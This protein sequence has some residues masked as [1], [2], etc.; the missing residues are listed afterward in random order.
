MSEGDTSIPAGPT[1]PPIAIPPPL[2]DS[3]QDLH[4]LSA[5]T[6]RTTPEG[7]VQIQ[8]EL[9]KEWIP[10]GKSKT[11]PYA[12]TMH[13]DRSSCRKTRKDNE[14]ARA[15]ELKRERFLKQFEDPTRSSAASSSAT[16]SPLSSTSTSATP[17]SLQN[18]MPDALPPA[19][20]AMLSGEPLTPA[21]AV[22]QERWKL[23]L[24]GLKLCP[25]VSLQWLPGLSLYNSYP[26]QLHLH[27]R[28]SL[29]FYFSGVY[30]H[31]QDFWVQSDDCN[32]SIPFEKSS[33]TPCSSLMGSK[34]LRDLRARAEA[35]PPSTNYMYGNYLQLSAQ[36][37]SGRALINKW[38]LEVHNLFLLRAINDL[39]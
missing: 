14:R 24:A 5:Y 12:Y 15:A 31:G 38:K 18:T 27:V 37:Q 10:L 13:F 4:P 6:H 7:T 28:K 1:A 25:G 36:L 26:W 20:Q 3:P 11:K 21:D 32:H 34:A 23:A 39:N 19:V 33:C 35:L 16:P 9:C 29:G 8:C 17:A 2:G 30:D 22:D